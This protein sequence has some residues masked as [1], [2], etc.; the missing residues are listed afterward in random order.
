MALAVGLAAVSCGTDKTMSAAVVASEGY[1]ANI[2]CSGISLASTEEELADALALWGY[3][4]G[5]VDAP[6]PGH[7]LILVGAAETADCSTVVLDPVVTTEGGSQIVTLPWS[8]KGDCELT[9]SQ[10]HSFII[11]VDAE[12]P[13]AVQWEGRPPLEEL[14]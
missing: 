11:D 13:F 9:N 5:Y 3:P 7:T 2:D 12:Q 6:R 4:A 1:C 8:N 10:T 14:K